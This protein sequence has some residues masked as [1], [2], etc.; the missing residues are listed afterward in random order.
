MVV[1]VVNMITFLR[2]GTFN[3]LFRDAFRENGVI[4]Y[5]LGKCRLVESRRTSGN[6]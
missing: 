2:K 3:N 5:T 1:K 4:R 6:P